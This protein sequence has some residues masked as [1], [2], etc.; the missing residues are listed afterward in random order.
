MKTCSGTTAVDP[1]VLRFRVAVDDV[2]TILSIRIL[3]NPTC[4]VSGPFHPREA[5]AH[6]C[7]RGFLAGIRDLP[8]AGI[9]V[10]T[11]PEPMVGD[12]E[13]PALVGGNT[14]PDFLPPVD[15][16]RQ[17][18]L[19]ETFISP[20]NIQVIDFLPRYRQVF[21]DHVRE[22]L[23]QPGAAGKHIAVRFDP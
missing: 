13:T 22:Q 2:V 12:R 1:G 11:R 3:A 21:P 15:P 7:T 19:M 5:G 10:K 23:A 20:G 6:L 8:I 17:L 4:Q 18:T 16:M 14:P 9:R